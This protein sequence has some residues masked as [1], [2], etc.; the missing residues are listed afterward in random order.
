M[1]TVAQSVVILK[2][3]CLLILRL[4]RLLDRHIPFPL[5]TQ[6]LRATLFVLAALQLQISGY[7]SSVATL[8]VVDMAK[9]ML[10]LITKARHIYTL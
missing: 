4:W 7:V 8:G 3:F 2:H 9:L 6:P 5:Q 1:C 10:R